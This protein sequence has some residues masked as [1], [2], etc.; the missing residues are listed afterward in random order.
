MNPVKNWQY[1]CILSFLLAT[2]C[3]VDIGQLLDTNPVPSSLPFLNRQKIWWKSMW[4]EIK[5]EMESFTSPCHGQNCLSLGKINLQLKWIWIMTKTKLK[6]SP[7]FF[8]GS[9]S[10]LHSWFFSLPSCLP[11]AAPFCSS[12]LPTLFPC[13]SLGSSSAT[14]PPENVQLLQHGVLHGLQSEYLLRCGL[15][16]RKIPSLPWSF[17]Q[18][19]RESLLCLEHLLPLLLSL[20][21]SHACFLYFSLSVFS[22]LSG[23]FFFLKYAF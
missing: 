16:C 11:W 14:V 6:P 22:L 8:S 13:S 2:V 3:G 5:M 10:L 9:N 17:P 1:Q 20:W 15:G 12:F 4:I 21:C 18:A 23:L 7:S 19:G